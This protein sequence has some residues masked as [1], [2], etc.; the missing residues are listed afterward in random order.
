MGSVVGIGGA[1]RAGK[2][3]LSHF[4]QTAFAGTSTILSMDDF[5]KSEEHIP[6]IRDRIDW[7]SPASVDYPK[8][9]DRTIACKADVELV[10][11][12]GI[13]V[14]AETTLSSLFDSSF[15]VEV[16]KE[17]F[18][19]RKHEDI[20]WDEPQWFIDHI[21]NSYLNYGIPRPDDCYMI[22]GATSPDSNKI[23]SIIQKLS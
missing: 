14:F 19:S 7:E 10:I 11:V 3:S 15:F 18:L 4:I 20:R 16:S 21:W 12:E 9:I 13:L 22:D 5:V 6:L 1:S 2:T 23:M 8:L 17:L